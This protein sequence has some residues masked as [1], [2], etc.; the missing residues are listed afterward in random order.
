MSKER[1][2]LPTNASFTDYVLGDLSGEDRS[3]FEAYVAGDAEAQELLE[4]TRN[5]YAAIVEEVEVE[6]PDEGELAAAEARNWERIEA[7]LAQEPAEV[8]PFPKSGDRA[9]SPTFEAA[10]TTLQKVFEIGI[11]IAGK[12]GLSDAEVWS[13]LEDALD[14]RLAEAKAAREIEATEGA[15]SDATARMRAADTLL[16]SP[17]IRKVVDRLARQGKAEIERGDESL[18]E[19]LDV[20]VKGGTARIVEGNGKRK[21]QILENRIPL[22]DRSSLTAILDGTRAVIEVLKTNVNQM[23]EPEGK[24]FRA[25]RYLRFLARPEEIKAFRQRLIQFVRAEAV[26]MDARCSAGDPDVQE[27]ILQYGLAPAAEGE[28]QPASG[29]GDDRKAGSP[30]C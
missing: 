23:F 25:L 9:P 15:K 18:E 29:E 11:D 8:I 2:T 16:S 19:I 12:F 14:Q 27:F 30:P 17:E 4:L 7:L 22:Y 26:K 13:A 3:A 5:L 1:T 20:M 28:T 10:M 6:I 24:E 21:F